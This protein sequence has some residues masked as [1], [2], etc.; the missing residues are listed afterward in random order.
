M[1]RVGYVHERICDLDNIK[2]AIMKSSLGKRKQK[3]VKEIAEKIDLYAE[4]IKQ[5]LINKTYIPSPYVIKVIQDGASKKART[6]HKPRYYPDQIIHWALMLQLQPMIL[7][8]MYKYNCGSIPGRGTSL[9]QKALRKW[10]DNDY[11]NT[12]YCL[13]MDI[14]KFYPSIN[15]QLL[16]DAFRR[17]IKDKDCL[18]LIDTIIDS[19]QGLPRGNYTSQWFSNFFLQGLDHYIKEKLGVKYYIRYVDDLVLLGRNKKKLHTARREIAEYLTKIRLQLK[20]NWQL[21]KVN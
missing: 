2:L 10:L 9:G 5:L 14:S 11:K 4:N 6:I 12:K 7:K 16:K 15:N 17:K 13:K 21:Y 20:N 3:R 18:W 8:G 1:K 19:S